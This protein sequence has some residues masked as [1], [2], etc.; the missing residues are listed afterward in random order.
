MSLLIVSATAV[1]YD[2]TYT[3]HT[4]PRTT[5]FVKTDLNPK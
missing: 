5:F 4:F 2:T 1:I 3:A